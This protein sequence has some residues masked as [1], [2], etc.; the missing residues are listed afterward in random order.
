MAVIDMEFDGR[1]RGPQ[2]MGTM[3]LGTA[4]AD[5]GSALRVGG[6]HYLGAYVDVT[7]NLST[8]VRFRVQS[9]YA[10]GGT[11]FLLPIVT[12]NTADI[13]VEDEYVEMNVDTDQKMLLAWELF[14]VVNFVQLQASVGT[15][16]GTAAT[17]DDCQVI[18]GF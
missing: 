14:A 7:I 15:A 10:D 11:K 17:L 1:F 2:D 12:E 8:D 4:W 6:A 18:T 13:Q 3:T 16:G 5:V 9:M